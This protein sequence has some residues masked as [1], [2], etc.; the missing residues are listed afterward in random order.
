MHI[1]RE[2]NLRYLSYFSTESLR[3]FMCELGVRVGICV[4]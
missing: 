3:A 1:T 2:D 4:E